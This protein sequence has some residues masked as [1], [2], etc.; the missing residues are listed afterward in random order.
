LK[1]NLGLPWEGDILLSAE[2]VAGRDER[3]SRKV[4][5][6]V[7]RLRTLLPALLLLLPACA[8][9][10][11]APPDVILIVVDSLRADHLSHQG[12]EFPTAASLDAF[13]ADA[14]L[15]T[16]AYAP[17]PAS[18][19]SVATLFT[20]LLPTRHRVGYEERLAPGAT[21]LAQRLQQAGYTTL[22]LSHHARVSGATG[23]DRGFERFEAT[24]G[25]LLAYPDASEAVAFVR[26]LVSHDPPRPLFLY[27]H[28]MNTHG[29]YR[30]PPDRQS[31]LLGR[32]PSTL[33]R[34]GDRL[35]REVIAGNAA[36]RARVGSAQV[37]SLT[38]QYD[39]AA[40]YTLDRVADILAVLKHAELYDGALIVL[41]G[42][43]GDELFEHGGFAH[44]VTLHREVLN[45][46]L[47]IK[48]PNATDGR[49]YDEPVGLVDV[50]PTVLEQLGLPPLAG[51]GRSLA[52]WLGGSAQP[53]AERELLFELPA[54][55]SPPRAIVAGRYKLISGAG[56]KQ[57][58][59]RVLDLRETED[60]AAGAGELV[61]ELSARL[62]AAFSSL[63]APESPGG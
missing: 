25:G 6:S 57:L 12:Y 26:E 51:D 54:G 30:V 13:R 33:M 37:R 50:A 55:G 62:D 14:A 41:T 24:H 19:P 63:A 9:R 21:T 43:H 42:D 22:A 53:D 39:A 52:A 56:R 32:P 20:G 16:Q 15:F 34:Y 36:A 44:G 59:D 17:S 47:Y 29:P 5:N 49:R 38:E 1:L 48:R 11:P 60:I 58:Y 28:L 7:T 18:A 45:V 27:L 23:L 2:D 40:R 8:D 61:N 3:V 10:Q 31:E 35:M 4:S 46:P